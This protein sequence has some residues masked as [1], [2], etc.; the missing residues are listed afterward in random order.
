MMRY[1]ECFPHQSNYEP[2]KRFLSEVLPEP[3]NPAADDPDHAGQD[4]EPRHLPPL[5]APTDRHEEGAEE[6]DR[7]GDSG[8]LTCHILL[9]REDHE[10]WK[11]YV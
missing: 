8:D 5:P 10:G 4:P 6:E 7:A 9:T 1:L 2:L 3:D 11:Y